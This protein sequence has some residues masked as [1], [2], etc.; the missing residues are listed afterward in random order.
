[1]LF[2]SVSQH[3]ESLGYKRGDDIKL[4]CLGQY[5]CNYREISCIES[6]EKDGTM[7]DDSGAYNHLEYSWKKLGLNGSV[8]EFID[9]ETGDSVRILGYS[10]L[11]IMNDG[12]LDNNL[13]QI[14]WPQIADLIEQN[15]DKIFTHPV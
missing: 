15:A 2:R 5:L 9:Y 10:D 1:M 14:K 8:G 13:P 6:F 4:C 12:D 11:A 7:R 3:E